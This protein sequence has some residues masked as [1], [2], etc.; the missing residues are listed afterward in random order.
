MNSSLSHREGLSSGLA[1]A[2]QLSEGYVKDQRMHDQNLARYFGGAASRASFD[3]F[4]TC[5]L[6]VT[7]WTHCENDLHS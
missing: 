7:H 5:E 2:Y 6:D 1:E 4:L 3:P